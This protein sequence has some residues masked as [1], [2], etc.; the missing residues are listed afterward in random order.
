MEG[1]TK[2]STSVDPKSCQVPSR[3]H[4]ALP[5]VRVFLLGR[6]ISST[7]SAA[8]ANK[9]CLPNFLRFGPVAPEK[10]KYLFFSGR[11]SH[12]QTC[13]R[14]ERIA[15]SLEAIIAYSDRVHLDVSQ[16]WT[17]RAIGRAPCALPSTALQHRDS[18]VSVHGCRACLAHSQ[19]ISRCGVG[20]WAVGQADAV[21]A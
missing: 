12:Q 3:I 15:A 2:T 6:R 19:G 1:S 18:D 13:T 21:D 10:E 20:T 11:R 8:Q 5:V 17:H 16:L 9:L 14:I 4:G 7:R